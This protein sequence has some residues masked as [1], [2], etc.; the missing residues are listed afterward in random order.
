M[1]YY[2]GSTMRNYYDGKIGT[3]RFWNVKAYRRPEDEEGLVGF[4]EQSHY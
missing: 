3:G 1:S 2:R 4:H